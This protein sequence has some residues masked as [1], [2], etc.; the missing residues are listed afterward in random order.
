MLLADFL[1][2]GV[3]ELEAL[4]PKEEARSILSILCGSFIGTKNYIHI[5]EPYY[6]IPSS[7]EAALKEAL[8]RLAKGEPIQYIT[9]FTEF[10]SLKFK[11]GREVLIPRPETEMLCKQA[12]KM[13]GMI[14]RMR[15]P[16]GKKAEP[17][18]ILDLCTGS[19]CI[20]WTLALSVPSSEVTAVDF[21]DEA[22]DLAR[23]QEF[24]LEI[25]EK[26][27]RPPVFIKA[28]ILDEACPIE[29]DFDLILSNPPYIMESEKTLMRP[30]VLD[31]E[32]HVALFVPDSDPLLF[33]RAI[34]RWSERLLK[35]DGSGIAEINE[36]LGEETKA[37]F[38]KSGFS[39]VELLKDFYDKNRFVLYKK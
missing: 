2:E 25:K 13:G 22:L 12:I 24:S 3:K 39:Q 9:G 26:G 37:L 11:V 19:G 1:K 4:Y 38:K 27:G 34:A 35:K 6:E 30:N 32:P 21:S 16:Y 36:A 7:K 14:H 31:Y 8:A 33:Y 15:I 29:G 20:A 23:K 10:C 28:D 18:R 17:V 5:I